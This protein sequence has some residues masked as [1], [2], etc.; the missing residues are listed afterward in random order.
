MRS[1]PF[2]S[3]VVP[4]LLSCIIGAPF[5]LI[6]CGESDSPSPQIAAPEFEMV[7]IPAGE[8][9]MGSRNEPDEGLPGTPIDEMA[10][11]YEEPQHVVYLDDYLVAKY[12]VTNT[13]YAAFLN[14]IGRVTGDD[15]HLFVDLDLA[16]LEM[17]GDGVYEPEPGYETHPV[18][19]VSWYGAT[20]YIEWA[21]DVTGKPYR[22]LTEAEWE[23]AARG[24]DARL[25]P[26]GNDFHAE[27]NGVTQHA[28]TAEQGVD[29]TMPVG[30]FPTG[31]S[32]YGVMDMSGNVDEWCQDW[33]SEFYSLEPKKNPKGP[34]T[35]LDRILRGGSWRNVDMAAR[36]ATRSH[37]R[38]H[39][40]YPNVG[41]RV[42]MDAVGP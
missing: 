11:E 26:W 42:G 28:N 24:T 3:M 17:T 5:L 18:M 10:D 20:A 23:K 19:A 35:G 34:E 15:G 33:L 6:G 22:L 4:P 32:P 40:I 25:F 21:R 37:T 12:E 36:C 38:P 41:F 31:A 27:I 1:K 30:S 16:H 14:A 7:S 9:I 2:L 13:Q 29:D 39:R 8:F